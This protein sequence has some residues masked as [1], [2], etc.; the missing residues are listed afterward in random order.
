MLQSQA[1]SVPPAADAQLLRALPEI[2]PL[3]HLE[4]GAADAQ[5]A[6]NIGRLLS[7]LLLL[8]CGNDLL[9]GVLFFRHVDSSSWFA[10]RASTA[11]VS[12][13][14]TDTS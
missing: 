11:N 12:V 5:L 3:P 14:Q 13:V 1:V 2:L 9:F 10:R 7:R 8:D 4:R 6:A